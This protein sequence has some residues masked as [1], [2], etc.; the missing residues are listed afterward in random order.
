LLSRGGGPDNAIRD[1]KRAISLDSKSADAYL[2]MGLALKKEHQNARP[3]QAL[4]KSLELD[5]ERM[6]TKDHFEKTPAQ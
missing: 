4:T 1:F 6:W 2:W 5:P 3:R